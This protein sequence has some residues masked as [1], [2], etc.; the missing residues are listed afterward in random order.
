MISPYRK[1]QISDLAEYISKNY[2]KGNITLLEDLIKFEEIHLH[3]DD[4][5]SSF[6]GALVFD[7]DQYHIHLNTYKNNL[8]NSNRGRFTLSHELG[9]YF[10]EE[11]HK[12]I[13]NGTYHFSNFNLEQSNKIE[14]EADYFAACLLFPHEK[15]REFCGGKQFS[16]NLIND[17]GIS[18]QASKISALKRFCEIGTHEILI[19]Y[20]QD[21]EVKWFDRSEDFPF[22]KFKFKIGSP[23]PIDSVSRDFFIN[24]ESYISKKRELYSGDWFH[25]SSER[26]MYE[27]CI[28]SKDYNYAISLIWFD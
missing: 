17:L 18:F 28:T 11:H 21:N 23:P 26:K 7:K 9:H 10:I 1:K 19:V 15:F 5:Q 22:M 4:Y 20:T 24:Q 25:V 27:Q 2:S 3:E 16:A 13:V 12:N 14:L 6:D 8:L